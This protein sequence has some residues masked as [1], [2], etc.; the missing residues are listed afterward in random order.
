M[1][2]TFFILL[3]PTAILLLLCV[4]AGGCRKNAN[5]RN[6]LNLVDDATVLSLSNQ[7]Y[8]T[9]LASNP[10]ITGTPE[11]QM[12]SRVGARIVAGVQSYLAAKGQS[13]LI[14]DYN[15]EFN[16]VSSTEV[17][18]W[19]M[20]GGKIVVYSGI[21]PVTQNDSGLAVVMGHEIAHAVLKHGSEQ[22]SEQLVVQYGGV[23][24]ST[25]L[26]S[27]PTETQQLFNSAYGVSTSL[28][29]LAHSR[30]Q[31]SEAD[32]MGL[33]FM[34]SAG[35]NP[36]TAISFWQRMQAQGTSSTPVFLSTHPSDAQRI[37]NITDLVPK[38]MAYYHP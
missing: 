9:F 4:I 15:W 26:S 16:L 36:T 1:R 7:Q 24:L 11:A 17:N 19:C 33:Y 10:P 25:L 27:K 37:Q 13:D 22:M 18:A 23:A 6:T 32:E 29:T 31:E 21:L 8:T 38:A 28:G 3:I 14:K 12:V 2:K 34:A 35:Y 20:P 30:K 5:G